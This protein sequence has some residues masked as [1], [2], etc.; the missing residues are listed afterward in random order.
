MFGG[1]KSTLA[2][3]GITVFGAALLAATFTVPPKTD[4]NEKLQLYDD[5]P[6][7]IIDEDEIDEDEAVREVEETPDDND[8]G[9]FA[10]D[11]DLLDDTSGFDPRAGIVNPDPVEDFET[12]S[13]GAQSEGEGD[14]S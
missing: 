6:A 13:Q 4:R 9:M 14:R 1:L 7:R 11:N 2:F 5:G 10:S 3:A 8:T 12:G